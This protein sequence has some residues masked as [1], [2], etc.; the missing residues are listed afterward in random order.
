MSFRLVFTTQKVAKRYE[1]TFY[2]RKHII[3]TV[4]GWGW[5]YGSVGSMLAAQA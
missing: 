1:E 2:Q 5:G 4:K 3:N